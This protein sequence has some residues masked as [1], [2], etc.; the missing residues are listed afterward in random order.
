MGIRYVIMVIYSRQMR[1]FTPGIIDSIIRVYF[2]LDANSN[3]NPR[4]YKPWLLSFDQLMRR[5][6]HDIIRRSKC[7]PASPRILAAIARVARSIFKADARAFDRTRPREP[8]RTWLNA[9]CQVC[10]VGGISRASPGDILFIARAGERLMRAD[11][12]AAIR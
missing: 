7:A 3:L 10:F 11:G 5:G 8:A 12:S 2:T 1:L 9:R 4:F 6:A